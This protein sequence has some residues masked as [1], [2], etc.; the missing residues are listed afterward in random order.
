[1]AACLRAKISKQLVYKSEN[2]FNFYSKKKLKYS[3]KIKP[4]IQ[5]SKSI[6]F[7]YCILGIVRSYFNVLVSNPQL[8]T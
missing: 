3:L 5:L 8:G 6:Y 7:V 1:M 2:G 4:H